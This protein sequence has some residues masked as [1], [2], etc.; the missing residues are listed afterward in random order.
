MAD[1]LNFTPTEAKFF[2]SMMQHLR[3]AID[4][5]AHS[6]VELLHITPHP[7][8]PALIRLQTDWTA[9]AED[10]KLANAGSAK[11]TWNNIKRKKG[12]G[13]GK[14][15]GTKTASPEKRKATE[16]ARPF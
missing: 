4:V 15:A 7:D 1:S 3:G 16:E 5:S 12:I 11:G 14:P 10:C 13:G 8:I 2:C 6:V 9:V